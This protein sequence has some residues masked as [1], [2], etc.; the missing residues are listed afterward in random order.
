MDAVTQTTHGSKQCHA[1][2]N[3]F[4]DMQYQPRRQ[5]AVIQH[6]GSQLL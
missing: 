6:L 4:L 5:V 1:E 2:P 3:T